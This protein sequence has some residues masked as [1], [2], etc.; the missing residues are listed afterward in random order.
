MK[1]FNLI[2]YILFVSVLFSS[3][4]KVIIEQ[5]VNCYS[6]CNKTVSVN[7]E[8]WVRDW[9]GLPITLE[10]SLHETVFEFQVDSV[11][12]TQLDSALIIKEL[13]ETCLSNE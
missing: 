12:H 9:K 4:N 13:V 7:T 5:N 2:K 1:L 8:V 10:L 3:C 11:L 6:I